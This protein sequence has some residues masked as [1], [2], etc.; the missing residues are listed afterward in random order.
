M[1]AKRR[2][3]ISEYS[4]SSAKLF[5]A[6]II[7]SS[8]S[9]AAAAQ[10]WRI[11]LGE[12]D[13]GDEAVRVAVADLC[14]YGAALGVAFEQVSDADAVSRGNAIVVGAAARNAQTAHLVESGAIQPAALPDPEGYAIT[15]IGSG[16]SRTLVVAGG[17]VI[18]DVYGLYWIWDRM[19]VEGRIPDINVVRTPAMKV[20]LGAAWGRQGM[21]GRD[22][23]QM[24]LAL[25]HSFNWVSGPAI[26]DLVPWKA[27]PEAETNRQNREAARK[28][29]DYAHSLHMKYF[30]FA[31][32]FT[33]HPS[34]LEETGATLN[35]SDPKFWDAVQ[36]KFRMLFTALPEL[37]GIELCN[38]DISGFWDRY[39][40]FDVTHDAPECDW[41]YEKRFRTFVSKVHDVVVGEFDKTY[42]HFTWGLREHEVHCQPEVFREIFRDLPTKNLY[43]MPKIT[44]GD[45]WWHQ[46]Y[47]A[48]FNQTTHPT[49]VLFETMNY[50]ESGASHIFPTFSGR[51]FQRGLQTFL[52][53]A[54]SNVR[55]AAALAGLAHDDWGTAGAYSYVLYRLMWNPNEPMEE[56]A[57]DFCAIHFG[58]DT[59]AEMA[60]IYM[61]SPAAYQYGLH[62]E[63]I[64][65]GQFNSLLHL[66]VGTFPADGY[67]VVDGGKEHL[68]FLRKIYLRCVPW[69]TETLGALAHGRATA[70]DMLARFAAVKGRLP[71]AALAA[72]IENRLHMTLNLIRTNI[73]YVENI[74]AYFDYREAPTDENRDALAAAYERLTTARADFQATPQYNYDLFGINVLAQNVEAI[75]ADR[76]KALD[77]L[78]Q[79]PNRRELE[80]LIAGQQQ[81][82]RELLDSY[83][84]EA[85]LFGRFKIL[86]DGQDIL[87]IQGGDYRIKNVR[88]D[89]AQVE[90]GDILAPLPRQRVTV[91]PHDIESRPMH[92]FIV[93]QPSEQND[94]TVKVYLDDAPGANGWMTFDLYYIPQPPES[95]DLQMP[96][97]S[98][99]G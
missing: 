70:E 14:E 74:F 85:V 76:D 8:S 67:P 7:L 81:R 61:L 97:A 20:R 57:R 72:D 93:E 42:F 90:V 17:S 11:I 50:Y 86:I 2:F 84:A 75:L 15:T 96:W 13:A 64:S 87:I 51:Y 3:P 80:S 45:R 54:D 26:L 73:G 88:W 18:G 65:Y 38:D 99:A 56:I 22:E 91:I 37:D 95:L 83:R 44:R 25:R 30:S 4:M 16:D 78:A 89:G 69:R 82:Y 46:P 32:E 19:R 55:G 5:L 6:C 28:L 58:R 79:T 98:S 52:A 49:I 27:E 29:I 92:P 62:I 59:A 60:D 35:P 31:N 33:F 94:Y 71:D 63:P 47:N 40:P 23:Q 43:L 21:G 10:P 77:R 9:A 48:T 66:R 12:A 41:S 39:A 68:E 53:P 34:L 24:R 36:Q 1:A